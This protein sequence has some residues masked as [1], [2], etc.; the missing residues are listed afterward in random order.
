MKRVE[1]VN[2]HCRR[3]DWPIGVD[4][5][6]T[7]CHYARQFRPSGKARVILNPNGSG[8]AIWSILGEAV[9]A[10]VRPI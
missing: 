3:T 5:F 1:I 2:E 6:R 4:G 8:W 10:E 7:A 9:I